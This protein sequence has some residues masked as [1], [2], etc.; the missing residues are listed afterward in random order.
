MATHK[1]TKNFQDLTFSDDYMFMLLMKRK[2]ICKGVLERILGI[3]IEY[4]EYPKVQKDIDLEMGLKG[5]RLDV[6]TE[7]RESMYTIEMQNVNLHLP[8]RAKFYESIAA[9]N[10]LEQ[11]EA[12]D[13]LR[14]NIVIFICTFDPFKKNLPLYNFTYTCNQDKDLHLNDGSEIIFLSTKGTLKNITPELENLIRYI[15]NGDT[16][17]TFTKQIDAEINR[18]KTNKALG[19]QYMERRMLVNKYFDYFMEEG[20]EEGMKRGIEE[21]KAQ[22]REIG[23][24]LGVEEGKA[25]GIEEGKAQEKQNLQQRTIKLYKEGT[26]DEN[27]AAKI[28]DI[29]PEEF[30]KLTQQ[31]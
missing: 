25:Q 24:A 2:E 5:V 27:V 1:I 17:D 23:K 14:K 26:I 3:K 19:R 20:I 10:D 6:Y 31:Q 15:D 9:V 21:G 8:Q 28:L 16:G 13:S 11:G 30:R 18:I 12:Y 22:G 7:N 4:L 29:A